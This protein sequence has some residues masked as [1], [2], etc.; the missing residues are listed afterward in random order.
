M[1]ETKLDSMDAIVWEGKPFQMAL[2]K[3][4]I[5][6]IMDPNDIVI[7]ITTA[8]ICGT[9]L[10]TYRGRFGSKNSPWI[11]GHEGIGTI[12]EVG[13]GV[14][15][16]NVGD[17][18]TVPGVISCGYCDNCV[19]GYESY[20]LTF[21]PPTIVDCPGMGD[22]F[23]PNLGGTQA[24][25][26]RVPFADSACLRLPPTTEHDLDYVLITDIF[27][28]AWHALDCSGFQ[29]GDTVTVFGAGPVG[30]LCAYS[31][32]L[33]GATRVY[34]VDHV[35][36]RLEKAASLGAIP[37]NFTEADPVETIL[38]R[39]PR[40]VRRC[41][42]CVGFE[43]V[44]AKLEPEENTVLN[45]CIK[46]TEPTGGIGLIG[47]YL[48]GQDPTPGVPLGSDKQ[49]LFPVLIGLLWIKG[50]SIQG[51]VVELR[52]LQPLL[53]KLIESGKAKPSVII[54]EVLYGLAE[55]P[56]AYERFASHKIVKPVIQFPV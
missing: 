20:C 24:H 51:G 19:R 32:F 52:R 10:H 35:S 3:Q 41:C 17:R 29:H 1:S 42:D 43:C 25:Y 56:H 50:L 34:S 47:L 16:L 14:K 21:N 12:V 33:R 26:I 23:G 54:D 5:P 40:G 9:D 7:R 49:G 53:Q 2:K 27:A 31:A 36:S 44:N 37:V 18:V 45:N 38:K 30:L 48:P 4:P 13:D 8:A 39:E 15:S 11:M 46:L 28:T 6:H 22:D 55:V